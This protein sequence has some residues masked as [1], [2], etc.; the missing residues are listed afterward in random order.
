MTSVPSPMCPAPPSKLLRFCPRTAFTVFF[1]QD[2]FRL[3]VRRPLDSQGRVVPKQ[4]LFG[5]GVVVIRAFIN[6]LGRIGKH[7]EAVRESGWDPHLKAILSTQ[8]SAVPMTKI[9]G[10]LAQAHCHVEHFTRDNPNYL[11]LGLL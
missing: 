4:G 8:P 7:Q 6:E 9:S 3:I 11:P 10:V 5:I 1:R 2:D